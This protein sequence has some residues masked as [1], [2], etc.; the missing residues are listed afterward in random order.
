MSETEFTYDMK[1][2]LARRISSLTDKKILVDIMLIIKKLNP[3]VQ[4]TDNENGVF[5]TFNHLTQQTYIDINN[6]LHT[7]A[8]KKKDDH[9]PQFSL[10][11]PYTSEECEYSNTPSKMSNKEKALL[12]KQRYSEQCEQ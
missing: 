9:T 12:K 6:Y 7:H 11:K 10:Y 8:Q 3:N 1:R 5:I 4:I 2:A